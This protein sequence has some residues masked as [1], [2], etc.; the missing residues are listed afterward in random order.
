M[1]LMLIATEFPPGPGGIGEHA[2][3]L[4]CHLHQKGWQIQVASPQAYVSAPAR[5]QFNQNL[6]FNMISLPGGKWG[7]W[8]RMPYLR[9]VG[10]EFKP[11]LLLGTGG[12][13][14]WSTALLSRLLDVPWLAVAHGSEFLVPSS[15][16]RQLT[17]QAARQADRIVA[18]SHYT[19]GIA[20]SAGVKK[21]NLVV[22]PNGAD[23]RRFKPGLD[24][25]TL[26]QEWGLNGRQVLLTVGHVSERKAQD[27]VIQALPTILIEHPDVIYVMAGL[28]SDQARLASLANQLGVGDHIRFLGVVSDKQL[29]LVYN[30]ADLF[31]LVS[32]AGKQGAVEGYGIVVLEAALCG[33]PAVVSEAFGL[34]E[35][36]VNGETGLTVPPE[37][38]EATAVA[39]KQLLKNDSLRQKLGAA[40]LK[41][42]GEATWAHR[43]S[44]YDE[45]CRGLI[46]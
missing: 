12:K 14:L 45:V 25:K 23:G 34:K 24:T 4:A 44:L 29:P 15:W 10:A 17:S 9:N 32:R 46:T 39:V 13:A 37:D 42:A 1:K 20:E 21:Q 43:A 18:V 41:R 5:T 11:D 8:Q 36:V 28:P 3:Q 33:V 26:R 7:K 40:A 27:I 31:V 30:L 38:V 35:A 22:I 6:P 16:Q 19:A 2:Y